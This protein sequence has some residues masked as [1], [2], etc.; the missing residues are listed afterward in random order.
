MSG[1]WPAECVVDIIDI[2]M[3]NGQRDSCETATSDCF[4]TQVV[5]DSSKQAANHVMPTVNITEQH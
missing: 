2:I 1:E 4:I 3:Y 5:S